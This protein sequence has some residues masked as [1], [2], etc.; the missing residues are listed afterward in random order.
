[1]SALAPAPPPP[2]TLNEVSRTIRELQDA[3]ERLDVSI[4]KPSRS[5]KLSLWL[6]GN[7]NLVSVTALA[8]FLGLATGSYFLGV[9]IYKVAGVKLDSHVTTALDP[10]SKQIQAAQADTRR[11]EG[12]L[13]VLQSKVLIQQLAALPQLQ[14]REHREELREARKF[15]ATA[16]PET[17]GFWPATFQLITLLSRAT[18]A[19]EVEKPKEILIRDISGVPYAG[20]FGERIVLAGQIKNT[21]FTDAIVRLD[22]DVHLENVTF[23]DCI[24]IFPDAP[25]PAKSLRQIASEF[26]SSDLMRITIHGS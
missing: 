20:E 6:R 12:M 13:I 23:I 16:N 10:V 5:A 7:R 24:I 25:K 22:P 4:E 21:V 3:L 18:S 26:L 8:L 19:V 1:M 11:I 2:E 15:L 14:L 9:R 17:P